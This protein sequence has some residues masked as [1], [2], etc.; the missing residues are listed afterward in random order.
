MWQ[1]FQRSVAIN[2]GRTSGV[3]SNAPG[4][5]GDESIAAAFI[6]VLMGAFAG[7]LFGLM[8]HHVLRFASMFTGREAFGIGWAL[9]SGTALGAIVSTLFVVAADND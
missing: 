5:F 2:F 6:V 7:L 9:A 8:T 3:V 1:G 4:M